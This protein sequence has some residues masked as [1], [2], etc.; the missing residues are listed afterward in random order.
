M[1]RL[2]GL[3]AWLTAAAPAAAAATTTPAP[4]P[5]PYAG[6]YQPQGVDEIG[7]W[8]QLDEDERVLANSPILIRDEALNAYI[9]GVLC[10][11]VGAERCRAARLYI[12][13]TPL[14]NASMAPNGTL[15]LFSGLLLRVRSEAE[16]GAVLG[17]EFGHF[18]QRHTLASFR[19][20]RNSTDLLSWAALLASMAPYA[21]GAYNFQTM[22]ISVYG[23][24]ARFSRDQEREADLHGIGYLNGSALRPQS[25]AIVWQNMMTE[26][27]RSAAAR[28]QAH[29]RFDRE[30]FFASHPSDAERA[31]TMAALA[32]PDAATRDD[33]AARYAAA[34]APWLPLFLDDQIKLNDFGASD[35]LI[36][37]LSE[38][39]AT[40]PLWVARGD[41]YR[42]RGYPRDL[43]SAAEFYGNAAGLDA[44][45][46]EAQRGLGLSLIK[47]GRRSDGVT[48]LRRYLQLKPDAPDAAMLGMLVSTPGQGQ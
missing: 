17:H 28:G 45:S 37:M 43:V 19:A 46:A 20:R 29:P 41:L 7:L 4:L 23:R 16:L 38:R 2:V 40:A 12:L 22:Q 25:A 36:G 6:A 11:T 30:P 32:A 1:R 8:K 48:A 39:G 33:G 10:A 35:Y 3:C 14:V 47:I 13:R 31:V 5:P 9:R 27:E 44:N 18:E 15:R 26:A 21:G 24:L 42:A 34:L